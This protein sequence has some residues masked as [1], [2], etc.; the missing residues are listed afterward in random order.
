MLASSCWKWFQ[1]PLLLWASWE[2]RCVQTTAPWCGV[3][4]P[5]FWKHF[6]E[7]ISAPLSPNLG[8]P[9]QTCLPTSSP[10]GAST[11]FSFTPRQI[12]LLNTSAFKAL[13]IKVFAKNIISRSEIT[14]PLQ[15]NIEHRHC[16]RKLN[17]FHKRV[18][19]DFHPV[20]TPHFPCSFLQ[21][22]NRRQPI[23]FKVFFICANYLAKLGKEVKLWV[24]F[25]RWPG[26]P[27][28]S[29]FKFYVVKS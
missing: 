11:A 16:K 4:A 15:E 14:S 28:A 17:M 10:P 20:C 8:S 9:H 5:Q 2:A 6:P 29:I 25:P 26:K 18:Q 27:N 23:I 12:F 21:R 13:N 22:N 1:D 3:L 19:F 24:F 7:P